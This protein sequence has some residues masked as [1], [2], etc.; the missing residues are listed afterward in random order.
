MG[1]ASLGQDGGGQAAN[2]PLNPL[3]DGRFARRSGKS[4]FFSLT[5]V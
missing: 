3:A 5:A 4:N 1:N 2:H